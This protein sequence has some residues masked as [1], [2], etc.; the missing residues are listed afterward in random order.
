[1]VF[2]LSL[3]LK[4]AFT[5]SSFYF[6]NGTNLM[7]TL[8]KKVF[9]YRNFCSCLFM[10]GKMTAKMFFF[11]I[12]TVCILS[13]S[14]NFS[15]WSRVKKLKLQHIAISNSNTCRIEILNTTRN[16]YRIGTQVS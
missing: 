11:I 5:N 8:F 7:G 13:V 16:T 14:F 6:I 12:V 3:R 9:F 1:M 2:K 4:K 15:P 10:S